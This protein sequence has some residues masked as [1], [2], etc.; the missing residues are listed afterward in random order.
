VC[1]N[2]RRSR[3]IGEELIKKGFDNLINLK[4]GVDQWADDIDVS[5][6]KYGMKEIIENS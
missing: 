1:H 3:H 5:M 4:G 6:P 2:G